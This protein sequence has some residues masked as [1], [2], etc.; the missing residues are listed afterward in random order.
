M[1]R[2]TLTSPLE[3]TDFMLSSSQIVPQKPPDDPTIE[4]DKNESLNVSQMTAVQPSAP[5]Q[6][7]CYAPVKPNKGQLPLMCHESTTD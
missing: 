7:S 4:L 1:I 5:K 6:P 2:A 3:E